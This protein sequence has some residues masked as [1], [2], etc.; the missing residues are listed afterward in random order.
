MDE[1]EKFEGDPA[2]LSAII[3]IRRHPKL[4]L[5]VKRK[6]SLTARACRRE[7]RLIVVKRRTCLW[8]ETYLIACGENDVL[9]SVEQGE[10]RTN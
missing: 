9:T 1:S 10:S 5:I 8:I 7:F 2:H 4:L 6:T 3:I